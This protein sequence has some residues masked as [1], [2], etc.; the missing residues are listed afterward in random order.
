[1]RCVSSCHHGT[2][3][4]LIEPAPHRS[5]PPSILTHQRK[6]TT[7]VSLPLWELCPRR[8]HP[9]GPSEPKSESLGS[10]GIKLKKQPFTGEE[11]AWLKMHGE[12]DVVMHVT[13]PDTQGFYPIGTHSG[14]LKIDYQK[15]NPNGRYVVFQIGDGE[16]VSNNDLEAT[17]RPLTRN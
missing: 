8:E 6:G 17:I 7:R 10:H 15:S 5:G 4:K 16:K 9:A 14:L 1:M 12:R 13:T 3:Q 11:A 2:R